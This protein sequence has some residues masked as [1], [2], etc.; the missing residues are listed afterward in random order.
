MDGVF[1]L[2]GEKNLLWGMCF[3]TVQNCALMSIED[4]QKRKLMSL[5]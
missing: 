5:N 2:I 1:H 3:K 4:E